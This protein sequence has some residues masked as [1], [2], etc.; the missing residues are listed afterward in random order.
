MTVLR[1][2]LAVAL[3][4]AL[5]AAAAPV[6][7]DA[8]EANA[9]SAGHVAAVDVRDAVVA[10]AASTPAPP[11]AP[12]AERTV[13]LTLPRADAATAPAA[14]LVGSAP[15][16]PDAPTTDVA[17]VRVG[18]ELRTTLLPVDLRVRAADGTLRDDATGLRITHGATLTLRYVLV[19]RTPTVVVAPAAGATVYTRARHDGAA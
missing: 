19:D 7:E 12:A 3:A 10:L 6:V 14:L 13:A 2:L 5:T 17:A 15:D 9:A 8:R 18:G 1:V 16:T 4:G 11:G